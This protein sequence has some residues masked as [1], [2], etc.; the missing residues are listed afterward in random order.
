MFE[1]EDKELSISDEL[2]RKIQ[3]KSHIKDFQMLIWCL[4]WDSDPHDIA[5]TGF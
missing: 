3:K 4:W 1:I 5:T 2:N